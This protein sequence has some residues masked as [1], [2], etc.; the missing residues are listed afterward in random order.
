MN[1][2]ILPTGKYL[3]GDLCYIKNFRDEEVWE[4]MIEPYI[5]NKV[6]T[7]RSGRQYVILKTAYGDGSYSDQDGNEYWVDS[8]TIGIMQWDHAITDSPQGRVHEFGSDFN[9]YNDNGILHF[10]AMY[11]DTVGNANYG[12]EDE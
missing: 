3:I 6:R 9:V 10:G 8:G 1:I 4:Q 11:I 12:D 5:E 2:A 7:L